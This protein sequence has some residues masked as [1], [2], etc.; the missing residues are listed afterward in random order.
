MDN[1]GYD[2]T[3]LRCRLLDVKDFW[4]TTFRVC[5]E[6]QMLA[7]AARNAPQGPAQSLHDLSAQYLRQVRDLCNPMIEVLR[8][9]SSG[10]GLDF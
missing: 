10:R 5:E 6:L 1:A 8:A 3:D 4:E 2:C 9:Y 7:Y